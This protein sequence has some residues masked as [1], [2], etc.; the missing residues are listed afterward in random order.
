M[1]LTQA[2]HSGQTA[3]MINASDLPNFT[4][5]TGLTATATTWTLYEA[6]LQDLKY[7]GVLFTEKKAA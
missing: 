2:G 4:P 5:P 7:R 3:T 1:A 6:W